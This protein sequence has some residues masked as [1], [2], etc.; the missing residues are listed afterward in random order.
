MTLSNV[1]D[2]FVIYYDSCTFDELILIAKA[3]D[4][5]VRSFV[6]IRLFAP[7]KTIDFPSQ[8]LARFRVGLCIK[9]INC[10]VLLQFY[11]LF[12][13]VNSVPTNSSFNSLCAKLHLMNICFRA[14]SPFHG[15]LYLTMYISREFLLKMQYLVQIPPN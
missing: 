13:D 1:G 4:P 5:S 2:F 10:F 7:R 12:Y 9:Q 14:F 8:H 6:S 11:L 15:R 3:I